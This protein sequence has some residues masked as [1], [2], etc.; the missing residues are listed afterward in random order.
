M[1]RAGVQVSDLWRSRVLLRAPLTQ[2]RVLGQLDRP[3]PRLEHV[4]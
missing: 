2:Q 3:Q 1:T 4:V